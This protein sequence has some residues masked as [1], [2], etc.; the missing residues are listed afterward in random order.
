MNSG[1]WTGI[2]EERRI[3]LQGWKVQCYLNMHD[4][5]AQSFQCYPK[6]ELQAHS[7]WM[8]MYYIAYQRQQISFTTRPRYRCSS[9]AILAPS[10]P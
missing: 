3:K 9:L 7:L 1:I 2:G 6:S 5:S 4:E 8:Y 10:P